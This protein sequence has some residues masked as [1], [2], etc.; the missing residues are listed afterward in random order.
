MKIYKD[1]FGEMVEKLNESSLNRVSSGHN[2][3]GFVIISASRGNKSAQENNNNYKE[4][5]R[6]VKELGYSFVPVFGGFVENGTDEVFEQSLQVY[7]ISSTVISKEYDF[8]KFQEDMINLAKKYEQ[9]AILI[10]RPD[11]NP[12][13]YDCKNNKWT[14]EFSG[15]TYNDLMQKYFT[16]LKKWKSSYDKGNPQRFSYVESYM[17]VQ[18]ETI[19]EAAKRGYSGE[20]VYY[21]HK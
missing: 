12:M 16:S 11:K 3:I 18:P 19:M 5:K 17:R 15:I 6:K 9:D 14:D 20:L 4:L 13:F 10:K 1:V 2:N 8:D 21:N 7:P